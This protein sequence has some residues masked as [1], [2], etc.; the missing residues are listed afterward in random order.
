MGSNELFLRALITILVVVNFFVFRKYV[1]PS[2]KKDGKYEIYKWYSRIG[3]VVITA[4]VLYAIKIL[5]TGA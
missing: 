5:V 3:N 1:L 2:L 4:I